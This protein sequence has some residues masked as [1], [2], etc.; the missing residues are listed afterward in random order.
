MNSNKARSNQERLRRTFKQD[1]MKTFKRF[2]ENFQS[3]HIKMRAYKRL[4]K[5]L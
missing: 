4:K 2:K 5:N 1:Q 3:K